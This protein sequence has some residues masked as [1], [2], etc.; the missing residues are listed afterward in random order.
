MLDK[1]IQHLNLS[2]Q[3]DKILIEQNNQSLISL[4]VNAVLLTTEKQTVKSRGNYMTF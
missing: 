3:N 1:Y 4:K 2:E